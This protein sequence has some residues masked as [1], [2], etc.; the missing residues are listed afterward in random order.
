MN[1]ILRQRPRPDD[2]GPLPEHNEPGAHLWSNP[3]MTPER[4]FI[5][6]SGLSKPSEEKAKALMGGSPPGEHPLS[7]Q[8]SKRTPPPRKEGK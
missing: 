3:V 7:V 2:P 1:H 5:T 6:V 4:G 8:I